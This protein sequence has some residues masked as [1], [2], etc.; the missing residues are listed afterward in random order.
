MKEKLTCS[1]CG[2]VLTSETA[3][4][5]DGKTLCKHCLDEQTTICDCCEQR[6]WLENAEC[7]GYTSLCMSCYDELY[8]RC[9]DCGYIIRRDDAN[10]YGDDPYC[11]ECYRKLNDRA[12]H[13]Y[14]YKPEPIFYG[15]DNLLYGVELEIDKGGECDDN[16]EILLDTANTGEERIYCKHDGSIS[17]GFEIVSHPMTLDYHTNSMNWLAIFNKAVEMGYCSHNTTTCGLHIHVN[18]TAF[19]KTR[20]E[21]EAVIARIVHFVEKHWWEI[22]KFSRRTENNL[23]RWA[24]RYATISADVR[25]TYKKAKDKRLGRYV[26]INLENYTTIEFRLFRGTLRYKTFLAVLQLVD[27]ICRLA[28]MLDDRAFESMSWLEFVM[29]ISKTNKPELVEYLKSKRL[30]VNEASKESEEV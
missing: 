17:N 19:G 20:D 13:P 2:A 26:A 16:A 21:Q 25:D 7:D 11:D 15:S 6:I 28:I 9:E 12:I 3:Q 4:V 29:N 10:Y 8:T 18:R 23:N 22:V 27:E 1:V 5:F 14:D 30:Y 24:A